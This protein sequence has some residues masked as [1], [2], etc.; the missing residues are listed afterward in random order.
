[1]LRWFRHVDS[2]SHHSPL[3]DIGLSKCSLSRSIFGYSHPA[4]ASHP[5]QI[6]TPPG[7][8]A[9]YTTFTETRSPL[10]NSFT[11]RHS[12]N[13][14]TKREKEKSPSDGH[15]QCEKEMVDN[16]IACQQI[17]EI[18]PHSDQLC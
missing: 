18:E 16:L 6:I 9:S 2:S 7:L 12:I 15:S 10:Q 3:L 8:R 5:E 14:P 11:H 13:R 4:F 1:M 17:F